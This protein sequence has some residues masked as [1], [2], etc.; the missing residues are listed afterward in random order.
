MPR[1]KERLKGTIGP[2]PVDSTLPTP[3]ECP[4]RTLR[5]PSP[6]TTTHNHYGETAKHN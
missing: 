4:R 1:P 2:K 5:P 3:K 6:R